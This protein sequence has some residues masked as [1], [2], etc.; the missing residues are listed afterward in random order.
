MNVNKLVAMVAVVVI[1][2][3]IMPSAFSTSGT[4]IGTEHSNPATTLYGKEFIGNGLSIEMDYDDDEY[5]I[6]N[7]QSDNVGLIVTDNSIIKFDPTDNN[8]YIY[9]GTETDSFTTTGTITASADILFGTST[10]FVTD[11]TTLSITITPDLSYKL[12]ST[13]TVTVGGVAYTSG[14]FVNGTYTMPI[15]DITGAVNISVTCEEDTLPSATGAVTHDANNNDY[16][17]IDGILYVTKGSG[18]GVTTQGSGVGSSLIKS[19]FGSSLPNAIVIDGSITEIKDYFASNIPSITKVVF[20]NGTTTI[21]GYVFYGTG[22]TSLVFPNSVATIGDMQG[23]T[24]LKTVIL[25]ENLGQASASFDGCTSLETVIIKSGTTQMNTTNTFR[26]CDIQTLVT[27]STLKKVGISGF[28]G[29]TDLVGSAENIKVYINYY[30]STGGNEWQKTFYFNNGVFPVG[31]YIG[32]P[33]VALTYYN[34]AWGNSGYNFVGVDTFPTIQN[35]IVYS[36]SIQYTT[37]ATLTSLEITYDNKVVTITSSA[38]EKTLQNVNSMILLNKVITTSEYK[39][40]S[41]SITSDYYTKNKELTFGLMGNGYII[42]GSTQTLGTGLTITATTSTIIDDV[43]K[44]YNANTTPVTI[45]DVTGTQYTI[46]EKAVYETQ[47]EKFPTMY[48]IISVIF[49]VVLCGL[50]VAFTK[51]D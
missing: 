33:T 13:I 26:N 12:P 45:T 25:P 42:K 2:V 6:N 51:F 37:P 4:Q 17:I 16:Y 29:N 10:G 27:P 19:L 24:S 15:S 8:V 50:L 5:T 41:S 20:R 36:T 21:G 9:K 32:V 48:L 39:V 14:T 22:V 44:K 11:T 43:I 40:Y 28:S 1:V 31:T 3:A 30:D 47:Q 38:G 35:G 34:A 49:I 7:G 46:L 23:M 18:T